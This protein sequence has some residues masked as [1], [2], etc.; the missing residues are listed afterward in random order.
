MSRSI[1]QDA[2]WAGGP[3]PW[4]SDAL[5][6]FASLNA[7]GF[8]LVAVCW[9]QSSGEDTARGQLTWLNVGLLGIGCCGAANATWL[10][11]GRR[12]IGL[13]R[14]RVLPA[15]VRFAPSESELH[16]DF[17]LTEARWVP[18]TQRF[19]R[20]GCAMLSGRDHRRLRASEVDPLF[21]CEVCEP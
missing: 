11:R 21:Q 1:A 7:I 10:L 2:R 14:R 6:R 16:P 19:H 3:A 17:T 8:V 5:V 20:P 9:F 18:G 12:S 4:S 13:A 15:P